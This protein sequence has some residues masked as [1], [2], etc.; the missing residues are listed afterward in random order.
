VYIPPWFLGVSKNVKIIFIGG[1]LWF[2]RRKCYWIEKK[3]T[4]VPP[5]NFSCG[6]LYEFVHSPAYDFSYDPPY[7]FFIWSPLY[8]VIYGSYYWNQSRKRSKHKY[9][10]I[11][12]LQIPAFFTNLENLTFKLHYIISSLD[13]SNPELIRILL[14]NSSVYPPPWKIA[15]FKFRGDIQRQWL[16]ST[17]SLDVSLQDSNIILNYRDDFRFL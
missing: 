15:I 12:D 11:D 7:N 9:G 3:N 4:M 16:W 10:W 5:M 1:T 14:Q 17:E 2:S 13:L 6:F 8:I